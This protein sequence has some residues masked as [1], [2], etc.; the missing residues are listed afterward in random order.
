MLHAR[1]AK[2]S[3]C[4]IQK[5]AVAFNLAFPNDKYAPTSFSKILMVLLVPTDIADE[6]PS[7]KPLARFGEISLRATVSVPKASMNE[8]HGASFRKDQIGTA[9]KLSHLR[10]KS[11]TQCVKRAADKQ[12]R[13][14]VNTTNTTHESTALS[15]RHYV[16]H[17][18]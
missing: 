7:P 1:R 13:F 5:R 8:D 9:G 14:R 18:I 11:I 12:L 3:N 15:R 6:L 17:V 4:P 10:T 2:K 16:G